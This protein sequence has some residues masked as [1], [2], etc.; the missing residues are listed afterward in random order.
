MEFRDQRRK[1]RERS[2]LVGACTVISPGKNPL[3]LER[4]RG[5]RDQTLLASVLDHGGP[6]Q[7]TVRKL[8]AAM[9]H[10]PP[11]GQSLLKLQPRFRCERILNVKR[12]ATIGALK[13]RCGAVAGMGDHLAHC[14]LTGEFLQ[15]SLTVSQPVRRRCFASRI[16]A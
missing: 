16:L 10:I 1:C 15:D 4:M 12:P 14:S 13:P 8:K 2:A 6:F 11:L 5:P 9:A 7:V 3:T